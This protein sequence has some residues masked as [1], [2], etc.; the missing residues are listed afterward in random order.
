M[1]RS[2]RELMQAVLNET[3]VLPAVTTLAS[4]ATAETIA[5]FVGK[6]GRLLVDR[7]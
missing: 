4:I 3:L 1:A 2:V 6:G 5:E 7:I